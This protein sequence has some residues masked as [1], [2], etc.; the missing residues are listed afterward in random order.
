MSGVGYSQRPLEDQIRADYGCDDISQP[1]SIFS[2]SDSIGSVQLVDG[3]TYLVQADGD[4]VYLLTS[5]G[6]HAAYG[7]TL[8]QT[9]YLLR[10]GHTKTIT[11]DR[12]TEY[13][14]GICKTETSGSVRYRRYR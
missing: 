8:P 14:L 3:A 5:T 12:G 2:V 13:L 11:L 9:G 6:D 7:G 1:F 10:D 4:D